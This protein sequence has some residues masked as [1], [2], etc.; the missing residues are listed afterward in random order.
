MHDMKLKI[1]AALLLCKL[2][3][4]FLRVMGRGG[5]ALPGKAAVWI[6][7]ELLKHTAKGVKCVAITG[8]N[9]KT[10]SAR[11][12][13]QFYIDSGIGFFSNKSGSNL[14]QGITAEFALN[15]KVTGKPIHKY[16]IIE[17][18]E[19]ASKKV[20]EYMD[21]VVVLVTN[22][23]RDQMGVTGDINATLDNIRFGIKNAPN[24]TVCLNADDSLTASIAGEITNKTVF[25]GVDLEIYENRMHEIS[26]A[27]N[28][29]RCNADYEYE[30]VT[31]GHLGGFRCPAC[32]YA[33]KTPDIA[34]TQLIT[35]DSDTQ[36]IALC[37]FDETADITINLPGGYNIY[38]AAGAI[39]AA[40]ESGFSL[41]AAKDALMRFECGF[42]RMEKLELS[43]VNVRMVLV[44]NPVGCNQAINYLLS[45]S[46][47]VLCA[48]CLNDRIADGTDISWIQDV[49]FE[50][51]R[52]MDERLRGILVS[53]TRADDMAKRLKHAGFPGESVRVFKS[54]G[55]MLDAAI[56]QGVPV[57]IMPTY[58]ALL[59]LRGIISRRF[60]VKN[61][62]E[63]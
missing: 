22:V 10:T 33:R 34:V 29:I 55:E 6:C 46:D 19:A 57:F 54:Q 38:N 25:Y 44:K 16:A 50:K 5:T 18:D 48:I 28:C 31:Y 8:T 36:T 1:V 49:R 21:P 41:Q 61:Y 51:L 39:T 43:G 60:G 37:A 53:G 58:T 17:C 7:P 24:A 59:E 11:M 45:L 13:E 12:V 23:F 35:H 62:W 4:F 63:K 47:D 9:G 32:G 56:G 2:L 20:F 30:Y 14:M 42:G 15:R 40:L 3:R 27:P 52:E 26:D